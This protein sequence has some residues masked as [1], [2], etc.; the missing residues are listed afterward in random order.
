M[1]VTLRSDVDSDDDADK[2]EVKDKGAKAN[3]VPKTT[4]KVGTQ[5][6][7]K[8]ATPVSPPELVV[9]PYKPKPP[10]PS[11]LKPDSME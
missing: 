8:C 6:A 7:T 9:P 5:E 11:R 3:E 2:I 10:Y 1:M 4:N